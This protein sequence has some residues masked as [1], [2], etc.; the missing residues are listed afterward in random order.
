MESEFS[1]LTGADVVLVE[2]AGPV[3]V[4]TIN[5]P[6]VRNAV[7]LATSLGVGSAMAAAERDPDVWAVVL[8]GAGGTAFCAG[9]DL[10]ALARGELVMPADD[11]AAWGFAGYT[12]HHIAKPTI[13]AVNGLALG[14]GTEIVLAS[15]LAIAA[16]SARFGLPEVAHGVFAGAGGVFRLPTQIPRKVAMEW[17]L[18]G[19]PVSAQRALEVGLVNRVVPDDQVLPE[20]LALA[21]R[22]CAN[23][24]LAVQASKRIA[25][26]IV[27]GQVAAES[28]QWALSETE[29]A[30]LMTSEDS[31]EG[32][33][34]FAEGRRPRWRAR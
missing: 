20:A 34:A 31:Q 32:P 28:A 24:P 15:D 3:M 22:I 19:E 8:T 25:N 4:I 10:K 12:T 17:I 5:R 11:R 33:R 2:R 1:R 13:A 29:G 26:G 18:T 27:D 14:G 6:D 9:V 16:E 30:R 21:E 23:A 7:D